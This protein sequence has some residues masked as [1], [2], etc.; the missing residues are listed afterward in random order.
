MTVTHD[1]LRSIMDSIWQSLIGD[2]LA[3]AG[4]EPAADDGRPRLIGRVEITG[5][6]E[7]A[8]T[9]DCD[10]ELADR[11]AA[12]MFGM[13]PGGLEAEEVR[14]ALGELAN[15]AGGNIKSL[16]PEPSNLS[17]PTVVDGQDGPL[18]PAQVLRSAAFVVDGRRITL[19]LVQP[20][21]G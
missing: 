19:S 3:A 20:V 2:G 8:V 16:L 9:V 13:E 5:E 21:A 10:A 11:L 17:L 18:Q 14:D 4:P 12:A 1:E 7:G 6:W 15:M